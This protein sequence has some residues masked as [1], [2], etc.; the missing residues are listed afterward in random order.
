MAR[1]RQSSDG[2]PEAEARPA[3]PRSLS[4]WSADRM[5][6]RFSPKNRIGHGLVSLAPWFD[7][8]LVLLFFVV[9]ASRVAVQPGIVVELPSAVFSDGLRSRHVAVVAA[10]APNQA[11]PAVVYYD[12]IRYRLDE[13]GRADLGAVW[14][15]GQGKEEGLILFVDG[16]VPSA[17]LNALLSMARSAGFP[18]VNLAHR[19]V[20]PVAGAQ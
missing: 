19:P 6:T 8:I 18:R 13:A 4:T 7:V 2:R 1:A 12:D 16:D 11:T 20:A 17:T 10:G 14:Q 9:T 15:T 5:R 3:A